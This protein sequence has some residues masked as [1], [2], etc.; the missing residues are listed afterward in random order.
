MQMTFLR[1]EL[2]VERLETEELRGKKLVYLCKCGSWDHYAGAKF[3][4]RC[5]EKID[6]DRKSELTDRIEELLVQWEKEINGVSTSRLLAY[7]LS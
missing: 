7:P 6:R 2:E 3:C 5:G 1:D 4:Y